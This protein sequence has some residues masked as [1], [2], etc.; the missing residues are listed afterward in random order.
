M[1]EVNLRLIA[2]R[3]GV[4][5]CACPLLRLYDPMKPLSRLTGACTAGVVLLGAWNALVPAH[6]L[7]INALSAA[8]AGWLGLPGIPL[9]AFAQLLTR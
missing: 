7:G 1:V 2:L 5:A 9:L 4:M 3:A 8:A 6:S